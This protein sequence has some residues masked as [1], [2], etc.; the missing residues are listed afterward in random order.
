MERTFYSFVVCAMLA[1]SGIAHA[2]NGP[3]PMPMA[4]VGRMLVFAGPNSS[5]LPVQASLHLDA[6]ASTVRWAADLGTLVDT[7]ERDTVRLE[8]SDGA[9]RRTFTFQ[10]EALRSLSMGYVDAVRG[11]YEDGFIFADGFHTRS[12]EVVECRRSVAGTAP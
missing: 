10:R 7:G 2:G 8:F 1:V 4:C 9:D 6:P 3:W 12:M 5:S 11:L